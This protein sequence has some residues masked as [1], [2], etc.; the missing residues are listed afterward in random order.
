MPRTIILLDIKPAEFP[1]KN[2][3]LQSEKKT[4]FSAATGLHESVSRHAGLQITKKQ[5]LPTAST[6]RTTEGRCLEIKSLVR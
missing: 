6:A 2:Q 3:F 1:V 4:K 5:K